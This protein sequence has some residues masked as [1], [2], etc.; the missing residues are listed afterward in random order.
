MTGRNDARRHDW[1]PALAAALLAGCGGISEREAGGYNGTLTEAPAEAPAATPS[2]SPSPSPS[3]AAYA[4][5][6]ETDVLDFAY[7]YPAAAAQWPALVADFRLAE[8]RLRRAAES[9]ARE[10]RDSAATDGRPF[11]RHAASVAWSVVTETPRFLSLSAKTYAFTGGAHGSPGFDALLWDKEAGER[12]D[13]VAVFRSPVLLQEAIGDAF[14]ARLDAER[15]KR[16]GAPVVRDADPFSAC[17]DVKEATLIL[18]S[19]DRRRIDRIGLLVGPYVAG[20]YAEGSFDLTLPVT[21]AVLDA[22]RP[23]YRSAFA[24]G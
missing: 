18:G 13:P 9:D 4:A 14:C 1:V 11:N 21:P 17:P 10:D 23:E 19:G 22:L 2:P 7:S 15:A 16:R 24:G 12:L 8:N 6:I 20:P 5:D 3:P